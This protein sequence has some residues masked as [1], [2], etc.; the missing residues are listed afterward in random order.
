M[1]TPG[2]SGMGMGIKSANM[3]GGKRLLRSKKEL[4]LEEYQAAIVQSSLSEAESIYQSYES[5]INTI[6][7]YL[8]LYGM[9]EI[10]E[11]FQ[12]NSYNNINENIY[13]WKIYNQSNLKLNEHGL[14]EMPFDLSDATLKG[15]GDHKEKMSEVISRYQIRVNNQKLK[16]DAFRNCSLSEECNSIIKKTPA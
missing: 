9:F 14:L 15:S 11:G 7:P 4:K 1:T 10:K 8:T 3:M 13:E 2:A 5:M 12:Y 6:Y 16:E